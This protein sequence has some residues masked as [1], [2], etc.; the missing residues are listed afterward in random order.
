MLNVSGRFFR[1]GYSYTHSWH[2]IS[3]VR[4]YVAAGCY[5]YVWVCVWVLI[6]IRWLSVTALLK[7]IVVDLNYTEPFCI[8]IFLFNIGN[9]ASLRGDFCNYE[10]MRLNKK[11]S[12][13][14]LIKSVRWS[15]NIGSDNSRANMPYNVFKTDDWFGSFDLILCTK[16]HCWNC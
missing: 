1:C 4:K 7:N 12:C 14:T 6:T 10:I 11:I 13:F 16:R 5:F 9:L 3:M 2:S 15:L 8:F